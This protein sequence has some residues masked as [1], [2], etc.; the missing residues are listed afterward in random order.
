MSS[1]AVCGRLWNCLVGRGT[2]YQDQGFRFFAAGIPRFE[3]AAIEQLLLIMT[4]SLDA[5][6]LG[7]AGWRCFLDFF[8]EVCNS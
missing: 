4:E 6:T 2:A 5:K 7:V 1:I 3:T 8:H